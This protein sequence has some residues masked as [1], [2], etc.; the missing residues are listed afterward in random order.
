VFAAIA[1][2]K[3][4]FFKKKGPRSGFR[5]R[6]FMLGRYE[7][8]LPRFVYDRN[9]NSTQLDLGPFSMFAP[10]HSRDPS[11]TSTLSPVSSEPTSPHLDASVLPIPLDIS[12]AS[13]TLSTA[14]SSASEPSTVADALKR[15]GTWVVGAIASHSRSSSETSNGRRGS[16]AGRPSTRSRRRRPRGILFFLPAIFT[17]SSSATRPTSPDFESISLPPIDSDVEAQTSQ[18]RPRPGTHSRSRSPMRMT[19]DDEAQMEA[20]PLLGDMLT[21]P[22]RPSFSGSRRPSMGAAPT[23]APPP[24]YASSRNIAPGAAWNAAA[25]SSTS[26]AEPQE[27]WD[28]WSSQDAPR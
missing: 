9:S 6:R 12:P 7:V 25:V 24:P 26:M 21:A 8:I 19:K 2:A 16:N 18:H 23:S 22:E 28:S 14:S 1:G 3:M 10:G 27:P 20:V 5:G 13:P 4:Y 15:A 17:P 11:G